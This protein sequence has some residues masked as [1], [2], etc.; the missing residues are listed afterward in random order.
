VYAIIS[1]V[2]QK[3]MDQYT[4]V[5]SPKDVVL[6]YLALNLQHWSESLAMESSST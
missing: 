5:P 6:K 1:V 4:V 3:V 2:K